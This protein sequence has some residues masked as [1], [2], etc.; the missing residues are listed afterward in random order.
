MKLFTEEDIQDFMKRTGS[1][2]E[3]AEHF[4]K[5]T[6]PMMGMSYEKFL[7]LGE[8]VS[9][10]LEENNVYNDEEDDEEEDDDN[11]NDYPPYLP[12]EHIR[13]YVIRVSLKCPSITIWR[14]FECPSNIS[15]RHFTDLILDLMDWT[16][17]HLNHIKVGKDTYYVPRY[18]HEPEWEVGDTRFQEDYTIAD[19]LST[20]GKKVCLRYDF[21]D[22]WDHEIL[23]SSIDE[24][25]EDE[26]RSIRFIGG[27]GA[28]PPEDC[29]GIYG[30]EE[31]LDLHK[32]LMGGKRLTREEKETLKWADI[33]KNFDPEYF[34]EFTCIDWC[35]YYSEDD[36]DEDDLWDEDEDEDE[37]ENED[38]T[39]LVI[40][41]TPLCDEVLKT[42]FNIADL[43]PW[44]SLAD[45][46]VFAV[47]MQDGS[48]VYIVV[49]G[50]GGGLRDIHIY[51]GAKSFQIYFDLLKGARMPQYE[52]LNDDIWAEYYS[53]TFGERG[54]GVTSNAEY[55]FLK[56]WSETHGIE[57][58][59]DIYPILRH[60]RP[61][62]FEQR[63]YTEEGEL[64]RIKEVLDAV[65]WLS[66][67]LNVT[68]DIY[69]FGFDSTHSYPSEKGGKV[70]PLVV[71]TADGYKI[72]TTTL[73]G[74]INDYPTVVLK[75][76]EL[77]PLRS[78]PKKGAINCKLMHCP[79][80]TRN[81]GSVVNTFFPLFVMC[82]QDKS[83]FCSTSELCEFSD[84]F[85]HDTLIS[86]TKKFLKDGTLPER[87][88]VD[89]PRTE[90]FMQDFCK[91]LGIT[92]ERKRKRIPLLAEACKDFFEKMMLPF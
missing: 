34:D 63:M 16:N 42:A 49:M 56:Q 61:H 62:L 10:A 88:K 80:P 51:D 43:A 11:K 59:E 41:T 75:D 77:S 90:A 44:F 13:K 55:S 22:S 71:K 18:Q 7:E 76:S 35:D 29:G 24:Y 89:D 33:D 86:F 53:L 31:I 50:N 28:C 60:Q 74:L 40:K 4:F 23:L 32:K 73:P 3:E 30:Y 2:R 68:F 67:Q 1:S 70:V 57:I 21:G 37:D 17:S 8:K 85:E 79:R 65:N 82:V 91:Q 38:E 81:K 78:L 58:G 64:V 15:L 12:A 36:E 92:L 26:D 19:I 9:K 69:K 5:E 52:V 47:R 84:Q 6:F 66:D 25:E 14:K 45:S 83:G 27:N 72:E 46:D 20:K 54:D 39:P 87:I 48:D